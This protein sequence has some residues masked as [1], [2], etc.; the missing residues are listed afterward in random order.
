MGLH[1]EGC[2][3]YHWWDDISM[4]IWM[5]RR[6]QPLLRYRG[7]AL[8]AEGTECAK[9]LMWEWI[10]LGMAQ[11]RVWG[12]WEEEPSPQI[13]AWKLITLST[14]CTTLSFPSSRVTAFS[15]TSSHDF[16]LGSVG[17]SSSSITIPHKLNFEYIFRK[18]QFSS[19]LNLKIFYKG[20]TT[21]Y[22]R[23]IGK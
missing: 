11:C 15:V 14:L 17:V 13:M 1:W 7:R 4:E 2:H 5:I 22:T 3:R 10:W 6:N 23:D 8:Q 16:C 12:V 18:W 20:D 21:L 19:K 9:T